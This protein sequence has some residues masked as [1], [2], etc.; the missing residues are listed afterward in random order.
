MT[1]EDARDTEQTGESLCRRHRSV[2]KPV[3][4]DPLHGRPGERLLSSVRQCVV[5]PTRES[6][7]H[8]LIPADAIA[9]HLV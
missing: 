6:R 4:A 9:E 7:T 2:A 8:P 3:G 5:A 1:C